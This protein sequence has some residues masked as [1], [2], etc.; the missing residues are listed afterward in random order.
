MDIVSVPG[1]K[2][3]V[4]VCDVC[5]RAVKA[6]CRQA[7]QDS[8][9]YYRR[10]PHLHVGDAAICVYCLLDLGFTEDEI[11]AA[12]IA[13]RLDVSVASYRVGSGS[14]NF[15]M[16]HLIPQYA[17]KTLGSRHVIDRLKLV[18]REKQGLWSATE[19][20]ASCCQ[21]VAIDHYIDFLLSIRAKK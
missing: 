5:A 6:V 15:G 13:A 10:L 1:G 19:G 16:Q 18:I 8:V 9:W 14:M 21:H 20:D 4:E 7:K 17:Q 11:A 12:V 2:A 3:D